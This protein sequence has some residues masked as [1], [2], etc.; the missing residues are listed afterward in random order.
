[1]VLPEFA[2]VAEIIV[3]D[4]LDVKPGEDVVILIDSRTPYEIGDFLRKAAI[5]VDAKV[6]LVELPK[7]PFGK[8]YGF[9]FLPPDP[10]SAAIKEADA[11]INLSLGYSG[12]LVDAL[13]PPPKAR[14]IYVGGSYLGQGSELDESLVRTMAE[15]DVQKLREEVNKVKNLLEKTNTA[16]ITSELGTDVTLD[17]R[18]VV[19]IPDHGFTRPEGPRYAWLP[20]G[21]C[22]IIDTVPMN[23]TLVFNGF[24]F[25]GDIR[26]IPSEPIRMKV[27]KNFITDVKGDKTMWPEVKR[28][29]D[30]FNDPN[31]YSIPAHVGIGL[32]PNVLL[33]KAAECER[34]RGSVLFGIA[35]NSVLSKL[36]D[37]SPKKTVKAPVH[38]DCQIIGATVY[39]GDT[40]V[41]DKGRIAV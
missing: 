13:G 2:K 27:E 33:T 14:G 8:D 3:S 20:P 34:Y 19:G 1:M 15:V 40:L 24:C 23:G 28:Y 32:N 21:L 6:T 35:D 7:P 29:L 5:S 39:M 31:V 22:S 36:L 38:W 18:G 26:G 16:R 25:A 12:P 9:A 17:I 37:L 4:L 41:V 10:V 11:I 30:S